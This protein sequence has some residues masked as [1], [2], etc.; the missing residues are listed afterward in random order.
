MIL[1]YLELVARVPIFRLTYELGVE[2]LPELLDSI[3]DA[4]ERLEAGS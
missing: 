2:R 1:S 3:E 4:L